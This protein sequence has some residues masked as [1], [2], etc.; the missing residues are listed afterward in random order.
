M[1]KKRTNGMSSQKIYSKFSKMIL[2][3]VPG[4][5]PGTSIFMEGNVKFRCIEGTA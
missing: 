4:E 5:M 3:D 2:F 1:T